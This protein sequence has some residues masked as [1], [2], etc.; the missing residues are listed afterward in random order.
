M[1]A[2]LADVDTIVA[3]KE[4]SGD[5]RRIVDIRRLTGDRFIPFCGLDDVVVESVVLGATGWVSG[6]SNVFPRES[7]TLFRLAR[8][9]RIAEAMALYDWF[10]PLLHLDARVDLVQAIKCAEHFVG[11]G[12]LHTRPPRL[13]LDAAEKAEIDAVLEAALAARPNLPEVGLPVAA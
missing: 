2:N 12:R 7:E 5:T 4:A 8:D 13:A 3:Y 1:I 10:M 6:L 11:R 9:G